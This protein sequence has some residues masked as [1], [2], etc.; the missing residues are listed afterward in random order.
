MLVYEVSVWLTCSSYIGVS[1]SRQKTC[2][3]GGVR[4]AVCALGVVGLSDGGRAESNEAEWARE[5]MGG[6]RGYHQAGDA[7]A[8]RCDCQPYEPVKH[9]SDARMQFRWAAKFGGV[10]ISVS[11]TRRSYGREELAK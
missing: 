4:G 7:E 6:R 3:R 2:W 10:A 1:Y 9:M 5:P 8:E 11:Y